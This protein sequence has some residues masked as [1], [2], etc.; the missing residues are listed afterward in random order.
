MGECRFAKYD[1]VTQSCQYV[2]EVSV[3]P[4]GEGYQWAAAYSNQVL[5]VVSLVAFR[6]LIGGIEWLLEA[7]GKLRGPKLSEKGKMMVE[8]SKSIAT[9]YNVGDKGTAGTGVRFEDVQVSCHPSCH[10]HAWLDM[11]R[12]MPEA[13]CAVPGWCELQLPRQTEVVAEAAGAVVVWGM[14]MHSCGTVGVA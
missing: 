5:L 2:M 6:S 8:M 3:V 11:R 4:P 12:V 1:W 10:L 9:S 14:D 7:T 13:P